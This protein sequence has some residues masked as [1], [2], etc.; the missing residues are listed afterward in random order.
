MG[1]AG[2]SSRGLVRVLASPGQVAMGSVSGLRVNRME[3][4]TVRG[5]EFGQ[6]GLHVLRWVSREGEDSEGGGYLP[7]GEGV[8]PLGGYPGRSVGVE[9]GQEAWGT[10]LTP[11][12]GGHW[13]STDGWGWGKRPEGP[14]LGGGMEME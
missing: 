14:G 9:V 12:W 1:R 3:P 4:F 10:W 5:Q 8:R 2:V 13:G 6:W 11:V 7:R